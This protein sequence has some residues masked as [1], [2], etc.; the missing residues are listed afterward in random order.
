MKS[1]FLIAVCAALVA[2]SSA[3]AAQVRVFPKFSAALNAD[4]TEVDPALV[5]SDDPYTP[6]LAP[7]AEKYVLKID[8]LMAIDD[9]QPDELGFGNAVFDFVLD[10]ESRLSPNE[11]GWQ[12]D[13]SRLDSNGHLPQGLVDKWDTL[14]DSPGPVDQLK[15]IAFGTNPRNFAGAGDPRRILGMFPFQNGGTPHADGEFVGSALVELSGTEPLGTIDIDLLDASIFDSSLRLTTDGVTVEGGRVTF[16]VPEP[17]SL[18]LLGL[19]GAVLALAV[20]R[21]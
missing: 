5:L 8:V 21:R 2:A 19:G 14:I 20:R 11:V 12:L 9:L 1:R 4:Y 13:L 3:E 18:M 16:G 15:G 6:V 7:R 17:S 10:P